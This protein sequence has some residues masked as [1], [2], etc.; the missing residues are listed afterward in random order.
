M[1]NKAQVFL[2]FALLKDQAQNQVKYT[3]SSRLDRNATAAVASG[4]VDSCGI[5]VSFFLVI[6]SFRRISDLIVLG[7]AR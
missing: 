5:V 6:R 3:N 1:E 4:V 7:Y 2:R